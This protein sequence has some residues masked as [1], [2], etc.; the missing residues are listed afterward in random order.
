MRWEFSRLQS[1]APGLRFI[2]L[3]QRPG[4]R[5]TPC[6]GQLGRQDNCQVAA[7]LSAATAW[8]NHSREIRMRCRTA[9]LVVAVGI[10]TAAAA[11]SQDENWARC[12]S[13]SIEA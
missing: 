6:F 3:W 10:M 4:G 9:A 13:R 11:Q 1:V 8:P 5:K 12:K 2:T 7:S